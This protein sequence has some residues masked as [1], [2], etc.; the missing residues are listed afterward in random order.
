[1]DSDGQI[2]EAGIPARI[3]HAL[4]DLPEKPDGSMLTT[5]T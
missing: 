3:R 1:M 5:T 4:A 2:I